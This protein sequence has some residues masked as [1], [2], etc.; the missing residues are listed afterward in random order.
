M[1]PGRKTSI[2][3]RKHEST[4][5]LLP[6]R[7]LVVAAFVVALAGCGGANNT[8]DANTAPQGID[9]PPGRDNSEALARAAD[10]HQQGKGLI[11]AKEFV[12]AAPLLEE[13]TELAPLEWEYHAN[14]GVAYKEVRRFAEARL[15]LLR[16]A[17]LTD[18]AERDRLRG[19][20]ADC[21]HKLAHAA[22]MIS[23]DKLAREHLRDALKLRPADAEMNML[24]GYV[25]HRRKEFA[26]AEQAFR[27]A[28]LGFTGARRHEALVWLGQAQ[29]AQ[30]N[31]EQAEYTLSI[32]INE[33][34]TDHDAYGWRAYA[35]YK[36]GR[37][38]EARRDFLNAAEHATTAE[39]KQEYLEAAGKFSQDGE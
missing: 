6:V 8:G 22:Y 28:S 23:E 12:K 15:E 35:R 33:G 10:L 39:R 18:G 16:A 20:A 1:T 34:V 14:L 32:V 30:E 11:A 29:F 19:E 37:N 9:A 21:S 24:L 36:L 3:P 7:A 31:Y 2:E 17:E 5:G 27:M 13:A 4:K 26:E 25:Q 38:A